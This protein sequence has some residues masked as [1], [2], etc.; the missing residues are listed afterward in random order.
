MALLY[1][2]MRLK[3]NS[4]KRFFGA[5]LRNNSFADEVYNLGGN[6]MSHQTIFA[7]GAL[8][9]HDFTP[10]S[11]FFKAVFLIAS[12]SVFLSFRFYLI[13]DKGAS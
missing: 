6:H 8:I 12:I 9:F 5:L 10:K 3:I 1:K 2:L 13:I 7:L 4:I 11:S